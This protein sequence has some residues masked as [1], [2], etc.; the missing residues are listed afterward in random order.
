MARIALLAIVCCLSLVAFPGCS[1]KAPIPDPFLA[2]EDEG[3]EIPVSEPRRIPR[4]LPKD[5]A[6]FCEPM[7]GNW[8]LLS[9]SLAGK[10]LDATMLNSLYLKF[11]DEFL[12]MKVGDIA[13][14][15]KYLL[16]SSASPRQLSIKSTEGRLAGK[17]VLAIYDFPE[18]GVVRI[19]YDLSGVGYPNVFEST[20]ENG[21]FLAT[22]KRSE[23]TGPEIF[24][25]LSLNLKDR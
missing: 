6:D 11:D 21:Y 5:R 4:F 23:S 18:A 17:N 19:C 7:E 15:G 20:S 3:P 25:Q 10:R 24:R 2:L 16:E 14:K 12:E 13:V 1:K 9:A 8:N 22:Y